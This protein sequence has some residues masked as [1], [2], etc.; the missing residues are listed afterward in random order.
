LIKIKIKHIDS[1]A[2]REAFREG[3][4]RHK[5]V[6]LGRIFGFTNGH[7]L[8]VAKGNGTSPARN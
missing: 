2:S 4:C 7:F 8:G 6:A 1:A 5:D 3:I